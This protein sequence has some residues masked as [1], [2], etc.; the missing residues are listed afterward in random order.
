MW[1]LEAS[2]LGSSSMFWRLYD[3]KITQAGIKIIL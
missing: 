2:V 3:Y 1:Y